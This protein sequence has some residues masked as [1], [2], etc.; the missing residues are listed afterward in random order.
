MKKRILVIDDDQAVCDLITQTLEAK[1][2]EVFIVS[3][4][5]EAVNNAKEIVPDLIFIGLLVHEANG[6]KISKSINSIESLKKIP[7]IMTIAYQG[8]LDPKY[9]ITIG[10]V[11]VIVKPL[12]ADKINAKTMKYLKEDIDPSVIKIVVKEPP[13]K[14]DVKPVEIEEEP[15]ELE[16]EE[17]EILE[18]TG[19][20][21]ET[22]EQEAI[23]LGE[24]DAEQG[25]Y[26]ESIEETLSEI[27]EKEEEI[28]E[29]AEPEVIDEWEHEFEETVEPIDTEIRDELEQELEETTE[30][31]EAEAK[32]EFGETTEKP[33]VEIEDELDR[34]LDE[35]SEQVETETK[36]EWEQEF[37]ETVEPIDTEIRDELEQ[38]LEETT[39]QLEAERKDDLD[40][41]L[42]DA[43][44]EKPLKKLVSLLAAVLVIAGLGIGS[45][46]L[47][48]IFFPDTG[49]DVPSTF[50]KKEA[51]VEKEV[52]T[53]KL[54]LDN[55]KI[56][57]VVPPITP[58]KAKAVP[59][60]PLLTKK[61]K[62]PEK[63]TY[64]IQAGAFSNEKNAFSYADKLKQKGYDA[65]VKK[66]LTADKKT[67]HRVL[68]G[69]FDDKGKALEQS[70]II[71]QKEGIKSIIYHN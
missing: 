32:L 52:I 29:P 31:L 37:E 18:Y 45:W 22:L 24:E 28:I 38:E 11:D 27:P 47:L 41:K 55:K 36:P 30:Q 57:D 49:K 61:A 64:S 66:D 67:I 16:V 2:F 42:Y 13:L 9:T 43:T 40:F 19:E 5:D 62:V 20:P 1:G 4:P 60:K 3:N 33:D 70:R 34:E 48:K 59:K 6:L 51:P 15:Y 50:V 39:E 12:T 23:L 7:I 17:A 63:R 26:A 14:K 21:L 58:E 46:Q 54:P 8:E 69:K 65:F 68:I 71:L 56:K 44:K 53:E 10:I 25:I 35:T